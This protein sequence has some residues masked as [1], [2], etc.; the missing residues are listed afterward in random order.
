[1]R[2]SGTACPRLR[3]WPRRQLWLQRSS[4]ATPVMPIPPVPRSWGSGG[5]HRPLPP[6]P[7]AEGAV[8]S[9]TAAS[10]WERPLLH[11]FPRTGPRRPPRL[12]GHSGGAGA[13]GG[14]RPVPGGAGQGPAPAGGE[15]G[16]SPLALP[17]LGTPLGRGG[18]RWHQAHRGSWF[19]SVLLG[20]HCRGYSCPPEIPQPGPSQ[21][22]RFTFSFWIH[23]FAPPSKTKICTALRFLLPGTFLLPRKVFPSP[24]CHLAVSASLC[25]FFY[26]MPQLC[27]HVQWMTFEFTLG[28][29]DGFPS[30]PDSLSR[31]A[32]FLHSKYTIPEAFQA[33]HCSSIS[34][35]RSPVQ[36]G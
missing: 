2:R 5:S 11:T 30:P 8:R 29:E 14:A 36:V 33:D 7:P 18:P 16:R 1:M 12:P 25:A 22:T 26:H 13:A 3:S 9:W 10:P 32:A 31:V 28:I 21:L 27:F 23:V 35:F 4:R 17:A 15:S 6:P 19:S 20:R 34:S 24:S